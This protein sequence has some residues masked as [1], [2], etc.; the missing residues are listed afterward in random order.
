ML[1][2]AKP[3]FEKLLWYDSRKK[4]NIFTPTGA[5]VSPNTTDAIHTLR[6]TTVKP[7]QDT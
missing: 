7:T 2:A 1:K 5:P 3:H 6:N 4:G